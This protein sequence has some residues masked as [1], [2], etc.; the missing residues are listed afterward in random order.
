MN[1][2]AVRSP[3]PH[4][5]G[6]VDG[7]TGWRKIRE[8]N[9]RYWPRFSEPEYRRRYREIRRLMST[10][11]IDCLVMMSNGYLSS[12]NLIYVANYIDILHGVVVFPLDGQPTVFALAYS[13]AAQAAAQ[14]VIEDVRW[15]AAINHAAIVD[16]LREGGFERAT[17]GICDS[18]P[19]DM[20]LHLREALPEA[21][22]IEAR[23]L[24]FEVR[25]CP[26]EEELDWYKKGA[27]LCDRAFEAAVEAVEPGMKEYELVGVIHGT[28]L[29]LG[30]S[31]YGAAIG[32]SPMDNPSTPY[33]WWVAGGST[34]EIQKGDLVLT[35]ITGTYYGYPGQLIRPIAL[36]DPPPELRKMADLAIDLYLDVQKVV[37]VGN[38]PRDVYR[39][40]QR[41]LDEGFTIQC[42][43]IHGYS[44]VL[45]PPFASVPNDPCWSV[46][47]DEPFR[48]NQLIVIEP[49]PTT[50]DLQRGFFIGGMNLVTKEGAVSLHDVPLE[51]TCV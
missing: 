50:P 42:P 45:Q 49:N 28:Y 13:F 51:L 8:Q 14:S 34:R 30:G 22:L 35:E 26:S 9:A 44:Q 48:E 5:P 1:A 31:L 25:L 20:W 32:V 15:G 16:R 23:D 10:R 33:S 7:E 36:G 18:L 38:T 17:I 46:M 27:R 12:A 43:V 41:I 24:M 4:P 37:K 6:V 19:H 21:K 40:S 2:P 29:Y 47:L 11:G 3:V 39:C